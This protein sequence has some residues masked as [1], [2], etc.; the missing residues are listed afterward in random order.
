LL[1][2]THAL[3]KDNRRMLKTLLRHQWYSFFGKLLMWAIVLLVPLYLYQQYVQPF[4]Q[5]FSHIATT[6]PSG[7]FGMPTS[8]DLQKLINSYQAGSQ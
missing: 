4:T 3:A 5:Q 2:E 8:T 7:L 6:T 1:Q